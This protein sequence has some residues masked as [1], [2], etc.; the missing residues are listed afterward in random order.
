LRGSA[1]NRRQGKSFT[2]ASRD[3]RKRRDRSHSP[4]C[5]PAPKP[6]PRAGAGR[7]A[8]LR[9]RVP[10]G[11]RRTGSTPTWRGSTSPAACSPRRGP[12]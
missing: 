5:S 9:R 4:A 2:W 7:G 12:A 6:A 11:C 8:D 1:G 3:G 10:R